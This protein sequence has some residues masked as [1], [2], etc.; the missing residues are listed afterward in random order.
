[1]K[2]SALNPQL[3][4]VFRFAPN[5][6]I[7]RPWRIRLVRRV[8]AALPEAKLPDGVTRERFDFP[9]GG[10]V[11]VFTPAGGGTGAALLFVHGGGMV[12]G[13][14]AQE[15]ARLAGI[16]HDLGIVTV[17]VEHR[18]APE[19]R[20]PAHLDDCFEAW[21]WVQQHAA[22]RGIDPGRVAVGGQSAG[23]GLAASLAQRIRDELPVQ[24]AAQWLF[25]PMLDDR[26]AADR[27][28][29]AL[30]H[31]LWNNRSNRIGWSAYLGKHPGRQDLPP[32]ASPARR[33]DLS[34]LPPAWIGAGD[35]ELFFAEDK[36]YADALQSAGVETTFEA[37][38]GAP[39]AFESVVPNAP[40]AREYRRGALNWLADRLG[41]NASREDTGDHRGAA[42]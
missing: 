28:L 40:V 5:P 36:A 6:P 25:C 33:T 8:L 10:G 1:M 14:A 22:D 12:I 21:Q 20:F 23:G 32:Y 27:S 30:G 39:H 42:G 7:G 16:A 26:T 3:R 9:A 17:S 18:L 19:H 11:R 29:D 2:A 38:A 15:D 31:F 13:N 37:V 35:I 4:S 34:G 24:P 41:V